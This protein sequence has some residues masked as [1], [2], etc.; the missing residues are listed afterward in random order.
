MG[1]P[2]FFEPV[3]SK[4]TFDTLAS[5]LRLST[6][7]Q[8][9]V[10]RKRALNHLSSAFPITVV[11]YRDDPTASW[12]IPMEQ[13]IRVVA[14]AREMCIEWILPVALYRTSGNCTPAQILN[15]IDVD[16][17]HVELAQQDKLRCVEQ[18]L[19][20]HTTAFS[21]IMEFLWNPTP[22]PG[23][24][25]QTVCARNRIAERRGME[26]WRRSCFPLK[27]WPS[28]NWRLVAACTVCVSGMK[29]AHQQ[30]VETFWDGLPQRFGLPGW[31]VLEQMKEH[32]LA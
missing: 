20:I 2:R 11:E 8:V 13:W 18:S 9:E 31:D 25:N 14:L 17:V 32:D 1:L 6:K 24:I 16:G 26:E 10:L 5:I 27:M 15:G 4:T 12:D 7:Y 22:I 21:E 23:C 19:A 28:K 29:S 30:A 3:P